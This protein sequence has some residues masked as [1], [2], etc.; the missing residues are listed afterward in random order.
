M[1]AQVVEAFAVLAGEFQD[2]R[3]VAQAAGSEL[4]FDE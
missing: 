2:I 1:T 4:E 3:L